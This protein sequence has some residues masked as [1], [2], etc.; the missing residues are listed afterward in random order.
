MQDAISREHHFCIGIALAVGVVN[1][2]FLTCRASYRH[3]FIIA[4]SEYNVGLL[5]ASK[6]ETFDWVIF[7][8]DSVLAIFVAA[9]SDVF[10]A[11]IEQIFLLVVSEGERAATGTADQRHALLIRL[12]RI[13]RRNFRALVRRIRQVNS[14]LCIGEQFKAIN[15]TV[16]ARNGDNAVFGE[17]AAAI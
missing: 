2:N 9:D 15:S 12:S 6:R 1:Q 14:A 10:A 8:I 7:K 17:E 4:K 11:I 13:D 3:C 5:F 16:A